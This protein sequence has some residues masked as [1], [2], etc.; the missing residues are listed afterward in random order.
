MKKAYKIIIFL[1]FAAIALMASAF[2]ALRIF[3]PEFFEPAKEYH[4]PDYTVVPL[5]GISVP[6][7]KEQIP[8]T[9]YQNSGV[10]YGV[11]VPRQRDK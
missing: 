10:R 11:G 8:N 1:I 4:S 7:Q 3:R 5:Y 2:L 9:K 6:D